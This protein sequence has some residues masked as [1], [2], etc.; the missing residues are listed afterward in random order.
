MMCVRMLGPLLVACFLSIRGLRH[1]WRELCCLESSVLRSHS[2]GLSLGM[3][4]WV[5]VPGGPGLEFWDLL[6]LYKKMKALVPW[7]I[8]HGVNI[9]RLLS[10]SEA[11]SGTCHLRKN[12]VGTA[13]G[14]ASWKPGRRAG[15]KPLQDCLR[16]CKCHRA[17]GPGDGEDKRGDGD[18]SACLQS[19][20]GR[21]SHRGCPCGK[22]RCVM[23]PE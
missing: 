14:G 7:L 4:S 2:P 8:F 17:E 6:R 10:L 20:G 12:R 1:L 13:P 15:L 3:G 21:G 22:D 19:S 9:F 18:C 23:V 16:P 5:W 11:T